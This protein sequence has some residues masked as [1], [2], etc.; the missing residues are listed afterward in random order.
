MPSS[1]KALGEAAGSGGD[2]GPG[3]VGAARSLSRSTKI[4]P[5][6]WPV[7]VCPAGR[8]RLAEVPADIGDPKVRVAEAA[9]EGLGRDER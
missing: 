2:G 9:G 8:A 6:M 7:V 1:P 3:P 4:A 5:G